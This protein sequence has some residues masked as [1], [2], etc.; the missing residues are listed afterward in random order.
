MDDA[1]RLLVYPIREL[2]G[3]TEIL[4]GG[5]IYPYLRKWQA[6][7][8]RAQTTDISLLKKAAMLVNAHRIG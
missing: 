1:Q 5:T 4:D 2:F 8:Y 6:C 3:G 7:G